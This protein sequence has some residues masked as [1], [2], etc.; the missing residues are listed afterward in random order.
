MI[1]LHE[2]VTYM[3][4]HNTYFFLLC[5]V[6]VS[7][8]NFLFYILGNLYINKAKSC[9]Y[10]NTMND[11]DLLQNEKIIILTFSRVSS[12]FLKLDLH[13]YSNYDVTLTFSDITVYVIPESEYH[14]IMSSLGVT[15]NNGNKG[16]F[17]TTDYRILISEFSIGN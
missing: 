11:R 3:V 1:P 5:L 9:R 15:I 10:S 8:I 14:G 2:P 7:K 16:N 12:C 6:S 17:S 13:R 4:Y